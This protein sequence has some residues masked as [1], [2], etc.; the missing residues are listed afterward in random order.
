MEIHFKKM[1]ALGN[2]FIV[3]TDGPA[4][5][6]SPEQIRHL[7]DRKRGIGADQLIICR[8]DSDLIHMDIFNADGTESGACGNATRC[9]AAYYMLKMQRD[10]LSVRTVAGDLHA[11]WANTEKTEV[12]VNMG[13]PKWGW[14]SIPLAHAS[15][16]LNINLPSA[17][18]VGAMSGCAV[19]VGNPH[20]VFFVENC[21]NIPLRDIGH[22][23]EFDALFPQRANVEFASLLEKGDIRMRVWERGAGITQAC[24]SGACATLVAALLK[25][26]AVKNNRAKIIMD[27]GTLDIAWQGTEDD[28]VLMTGGYE[29]VFEGVIDS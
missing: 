4:Q 19:N 8:K 24:G 25:N 15:D 29:F 16:T 6:L 12:T 1:Q 20:I 27:G 7:C 9:V 10:N 22:D 18:S 11:K 5:K 14:Q 26:M 21:E 17:Q 2:D 28:G 23:I 13:A 3:L